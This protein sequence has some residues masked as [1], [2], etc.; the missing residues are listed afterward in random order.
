MVDFISVTRLCD[1][2]EVSSSF[3]VQKPPK[4]APFTC[5][6]YAGSRAEQRPHQFERARAWAKAQCQNRMGQDL[7]T[8]KP[9]TAQQHQYREKAVSLPN[10]TRM[11]ED[12]ADIFT[13]R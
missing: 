11:G 10:R 8:T 13:A 4:E 9:G 5:E 3:R 7:Y 6:L 2:K 12:H 1:K